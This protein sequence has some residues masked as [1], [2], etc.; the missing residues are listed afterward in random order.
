MGSILLVGF[1]LSGGPPN[2]VGHKG[3][4]V[5]V[6]NWL[7]LLGGCTAMVAGVLATRTDHR[8]PA[9]RSR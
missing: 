4:T 2:L 5:A 9:R 8:G 1:L 7:M 3:T 6:G